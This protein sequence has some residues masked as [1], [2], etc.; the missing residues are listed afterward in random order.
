MSDYK[1]SD[2]RYHISKNYGLK[3][4]DVIE[5]LKMGN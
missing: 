3:V 5:V 1:D 4:T 2:E